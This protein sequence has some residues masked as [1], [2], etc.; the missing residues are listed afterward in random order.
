[1]FGRKI[2]VI[3]SNQIDKV[4]KLGIPELSKFIFAHV[5][6][7]LSASKD[8]PRYLAFGQHIVDNGRS[9]PYGAKGVLLGITQ[10]EPLAAQLPGN[11]S[12][13][14]VSAETLAYASVWEDQDF[15]AK[16]TPKCD[17]L[18]KK[19]KKHKDVDKLID[20]I[21]TSPWAHYIDLSAVA[22]A[23]HIRGP[24]EPGLAIPY[25]IV[26]HLMTPVEQ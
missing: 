1:M 21:D 15:R 25:Q 13:F 16:G 12:R 5:D 2:A 8:F 26:T 19:V 24:K 20:Q 17:A 11:V 3:T 7:T 23:L 9:T 18:N 14:C 6:D 10:H 4:E 22:R